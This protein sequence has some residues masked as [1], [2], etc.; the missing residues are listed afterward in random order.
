[1]IVSVRAA[2]VQADLPNLP[3]VQ[4]ADGANPNVSGRFIQ[5]Q[6]RL[7][8][9]QNDQSPILFDLLIATAD[10]AACKVDTDDDVDKL[11]LALIS[12]ARGKTAQPGDPRDA[13]RNGVINTIDVK[14]CTKQCTRP[15]CATQ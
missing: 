6:T 10:T 8:A 9:N 3:F 1:M 2:N 15:N 13:D 14:L 11:D 5:V 12:K 7:N 4:V